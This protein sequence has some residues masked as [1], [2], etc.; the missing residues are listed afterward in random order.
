MYRY[1]S[2]LRPV[3]IG[4]FPKKDCKINIHN[5][6]QREYVPS[7]DREAWGYIEYEEPLTEEE[8]RCYDLFGNKPR[9]E[10]RVYYER[11]NM[12]PDYYLGRKGIKRRWTARTPLE[13]CAK[14]QLYLNDYEGDTYSVWDGDECITGGA[15]DPGD[16]EYIKEYF[17]M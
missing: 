8:M 14:W 10:I 17:G 15:Y 11:Y 4:T 9:Y 3:G 16:I 2:I 13:L 12:D 5:F 1:Y 6:Y 7:I